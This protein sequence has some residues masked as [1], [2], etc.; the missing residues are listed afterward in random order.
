M[1]LIKGQNVIGNHFSPDIFCPKNPLRRFVKH[2][3]EYEIYRTRLYKN[4]LIVP[5]IGP[6]QEEKTKKENL[7]AIWYDKVTTKDRFS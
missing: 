2:K 4:I 6:H 7:S 3:R 1:T 5:F